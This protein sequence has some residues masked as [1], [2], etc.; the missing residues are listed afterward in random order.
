MKQIIDRVTI[1][2]ADASVDPTDLVA[3]SKRFPFVEWGIL[4]SKSQEASPRFPS[5]TWLRRLH[6]LS[7]T[8][9]LLLCG[10]ICGKW[11]RDICDGAWTILY[12]CKE[13]EDMFARFQLNFH[14][15]VHKLD[16]EKFLQGFD[17][18]R[19]Y[20]RQIIFQLDDV[21]NDILDVAR[22]AE[23]DAVA[24]FDTSGG[25]GRLPESWPTARDFYCGYAGGLS[26]ENL[27]AQL[28]S[29]SK[30]A[31]EGPIWIDVETRV[32]SEDDQILDLDKVVKFLEIAEPWVAQGVLA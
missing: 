8:E 2:G 7:Q 24:L 29:I 30:V 14:A 22:A 15:Q 23:I 26:P 31:G 9:E 10:H 19:L 32:R 21:N 13:F 12:D 4:L 18:E 28:L 5:K 3:L 20:F 11:V 17:N 1:T 6:E 27:N 16:R 25:V